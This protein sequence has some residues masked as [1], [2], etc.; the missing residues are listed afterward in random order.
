M[1]E[2]LSRQARNEAEKHWLAKFSG[3][4]ARAAQGASGRSDFLDLRQQDLARAV[5]V[6]AENIEW[7]LVG[8]YEQA[9]RKRLLVSPPWEAEAESKITCLK[10]TP[11]EFPGQSVSHRDYLG[12]LLNL[13]LK[14]EKLGDIVPQE[15]GAFVFADTDIAAY[16]T[17]QL[18]RVKHSTVSAEIIADQDFVYHPPEL[19]TLQV[20]L[21]SLRLDAAVAAVYKLSRSQVDRYITSGQVRINHLEVLKSSVAVKTGDLISVRGLGRFRLEELG[22]LSRK[23]RQYVQIS[24]W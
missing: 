3:L 11:K 4:A 8:G 13:G 19:T 18:T 23:G 9:E 12:A 6:N 14:R 2:Y 7:E 15:N 22:G 17:Q 24:R 5:A 1:N 21:A 10:I 16:L 20:N